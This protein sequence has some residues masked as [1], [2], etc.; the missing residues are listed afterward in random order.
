M[1]LAANVNAD[2]FTQDLM[3]RY[4]AAK[5]RDTRPGRTW[6]DADWLNQGLAPVRDT[7]QLDLPMDPANPALYL[8]ENKKKTVRVTFSRHSAADRKILQNPALGLTEN[9]AKRVNAAADLAAKNRTDA[10]S[11]VTAFYHANDLFVRLKRWKLHLGEMFRYV[12]L[13]LIVRY[14]HGM[15]VGPGKDGRTVN[16]V[17]VIDK[18]SSPWQIEARFGLA[19]LRASPEKSPLG[20]AC[21]P[22]WNWHEFGHVLLAGAIGELEFRF[23]HSAGDALAAIL[24]DPKSKLAADP[25]WRGVTFPWV[26]QPRRRH[27]RKVE[28]G[29][30]WNGALYQRERFFT[31]I[32]HCAKAGYWA[33]QI[34]SS[35]LFRLYRG[36]GGDTEQAANV[37]DEKARQAA[38][39]YTGFLI[40]K[41]IGIL[42]D[43]ASVPASTP[44]Q[45]ASAL[46]DADRGTHKFDDGLFNT[47]PRRRI[48]GA[49]RKVIRWAFQQQGLYARSTDGLPTA[50]PGDPED[51]D[52]DIA[53]LRNQ[54]TQGAP[55]T[56][57]PIKSSEWQASPAAIWIRRNAD[58]QEL[59]QAP[60]FGVHNWIYFKVRN[61][62]P[63]QADQVNMYVWAAEIGAG[64]LTDLNLKWRL[65]GSVG[66]AAIAGGAEAKLGPIDWDLTAVA[67]GKRFTLLVAANCPA[68]QA[69]VDRDTGLPCAFPND[70]AHNG[71]FKIACPI[72]Q[73]V[74]YDNNLGLRDLTTAP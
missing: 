42:G 60:Q 33:E 48:G 50:R 56:Y 26:T 59:D 54:A 30:G 5:F 38:A 52:L 9:D 65:V 4:G 23:G 66:P 63:Q 61:I 32:G 46:I 70:L 7:V 72:D 73:L 58:G 64:G 40:A 6:E 20:L 55:G 29:W 39:E 18:S 34:L 15:H 1:Q 68:D 19:D 62:G 49:A 14:R 67:Q 13:P 8:L 25:S 16:A 3:A 44:D 41:A 27:D 24:L 53:D 51:V 17:V 37:A 57:A 2:V 11:S 71:Q 12:K 31:D 45:F 74:A 69:N 10:T 28:D 36:L 43:A 47:G 35:T 21:D 22:R